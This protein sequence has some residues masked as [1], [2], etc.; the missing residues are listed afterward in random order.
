MFSNLTTGLYQK[1]AYIQNLRKK[2]L[3]C[4]ENEDFGNLAKNIHFA[5]QKIYLLYKRNSY[6]FVC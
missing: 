5:R 1:K 3:V 4:A 6:F 2:V